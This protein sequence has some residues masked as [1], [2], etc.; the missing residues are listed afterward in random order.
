[1]MR[2]SSFALLACAAACFGLLRMAGQPTPPSWQA[3][4]MFY[5]IFVRSF[6]DS[7]GD[8]TGN[9]HLH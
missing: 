6:K 7:D 8:C 4:T 2:P 9:F 1:M 3:E 5:E